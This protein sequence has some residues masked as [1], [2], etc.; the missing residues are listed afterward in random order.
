[1]D[2]LVS[3]IKEQKLNPDVVVG[4][5]GGATMDLAK[6][7]GICLNNPGAV[8]SYQGYSLALEKG[9]DIWVLP[10]L[11]GTGAE[12]TPIAVLRGPEKKLGINNKFAAPSLAVIDPDLSRKVKKFNRF[13]TMMD[14]YYHHFEITLS[15]TS[16]K[17]AVLD[18]HNGL[19]LTRQVLNN[20]L[21]Q[22]KEEL[23]I[24]SIYASILGGSSTIGGRVGACHALSYGLSNCGPALTYY[25]SINSWAAMFFP[26]RKFLAGYVGINV[27]RHLT[28]NF[29][30]SSDETF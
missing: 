28:W 20:D 29:Y 11:S 9:V 6:A 26:S 8:A 22:Y 27:A 30:D 3:L 14:C 1:M 5:G 2:Y 24:N 25:S 12:L 15:K 19:R 13:F 21:S 17:K 4:I 18:A 16:E 10:T 23:A 7:V